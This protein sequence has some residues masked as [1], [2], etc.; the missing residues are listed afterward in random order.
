MRIKDKVAIVTGG[1]NGIGTA[2]LTFKFFL[3]YV[4]RLAF[5]CLKFNISAEVK[6]FYANYRRPF[7]WPS[8][9]HV[10]Q[11]PFKNG[12]AFPEKSLTH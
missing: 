3:G 5:F 6:P 9:K 8:L 2:L 12:L 11:S 1:S 10:S 7:L 4:S